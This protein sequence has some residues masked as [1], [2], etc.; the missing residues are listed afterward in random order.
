MEK[1]RRTPQTPS[2]YLPQ[3]DGLRFVAFLLVFIHNA[4]PILLESHLRK[5]SEYG[6]IGVDLFFCISA[7]LITKILVHEY[8]SNKTI[9]GKNYLVR[10]ILKIGPQ[11]FLYIFLVYLLKDYIPNGNTK[12]LENLIGLWTF[13]YNFIY[14]YLLPSPALLFVH[15]WSISFEFQY[16]LILPTTV[17][18]LINTSTK[19]K[20]LL[21]SGV[22]IAGTVLRFL[23]VYFKFEH[24]L[25]YLLPFTHFESILGGIL[26]GTGM[27]DNFAK[28]FSGLA[29]F[30][31]GFIFNLSIFLLPNN[32]IISWKLLLTYPLLG[33]GMT[34]TVLSVLNKDVPIVS[35]LLTQ[36]P[37]VYLGKIS[38]G[39]YL[40]H[41]AAFFL[42]SQVLINFA[43]YSAIELSKNHLLVMLISFAVTCLVSA[44]SY[45]LIEKPFLTLKHR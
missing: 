24:P 12:I 30:V 22:V 4:K 9:N 28:N 45:N 19:Q 32:D 8:Q 13:T 16:Y 2:F 35:Q 26:L 15:L 5:I 40:F 42:T 44:V 39:L 25:I 38:Y 7:F 31:L 36:K 29:L 23:C 43:G 11:Y 10:R 21:L 1:E 17:I 37:V 27:L 41:I 18:T 34:L 6:W 3:L 14:F 20:S 33:T